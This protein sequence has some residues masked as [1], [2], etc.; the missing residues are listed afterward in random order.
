MVRMVASNRSKI[1]PSS[2]SAATRSRHCCVRAACSETGRVSR[3]ACLL[4]IVCFALAACGDPRVQIRDWTCVLGD[5][6]RLATTDG[7]IVHGVALA[8][9]ES[10]RTWAV[11]SERAGLFAREIDDHGVPS[12]EDF[13]VGP[14]C[15]GG[16]DAEAQNGVL[17]IACGRK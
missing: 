17:L 2:S 4:A 11:W 13:R 5:E 6:H 8:A 3:T 9:D 12:A 14:A 10:G 16:L 7:P 1:P 15:D